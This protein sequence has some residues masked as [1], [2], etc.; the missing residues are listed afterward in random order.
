MRRGEEI[1]C[2]VL[3]EVVDKVNGED[4]A[5]KQLAVST[6]EM[7]STAMAAQAE[8]SVK[9]RYAVAIRQPRDLDE[10]R[11]KILKECN[12]PLF[13]EQAIYKKPLGK[14]VEGLSIRF[15]EAAIRCMTNLLT[16]TMV[17]YDDQDKRVLRVSVTDLETNVSYFQDVTFEKTIERKKPQEGDVVLKKRR[18]SYGEYVCTIR[19]RD[20]DDIINKQNALVSKA[21]RTLGLRHIPG[22]IA[23]EAK[24]FCYKVQADKYAKDPDGAR[25]ALFDAFKTVGVSVPQI[26]LYLG[27]NADTLTEKELISL[28]GLY[29]A[30]KDGEATWEEATG[31]KPTKKGNVV[32]TEVEADKETEEK[33]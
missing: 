13:A 15:V 25:K 1:Q 10:V 24:A 18:N 4:E 9:A 3:P 23:D 26:K 14:N 32:A 11:E 30:I 2:N 21:I 17:V 8:A 33:K 7:S 19:A 29:T 16:E 31:N 12:R 27:H 28:R 6:S 20:D 5:C 22:D